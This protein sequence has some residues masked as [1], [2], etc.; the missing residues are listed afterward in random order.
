MLFDG[1]AT[2][3]ACLEEVLLSRESFGTRPAG[4]VLEL[5]S[6]PRSSGRAAA[7]PKS[8]ARYDRLRRHAMKNILDSAHRDCK[9]SK[10]LA[11]AAENCM[12]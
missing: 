3:L 10:R 8:F 2:R 4:G 7:P 11:G 6:L 5:C 9:D 1:F 12:K